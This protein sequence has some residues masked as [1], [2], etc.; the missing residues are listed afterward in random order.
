MPVIPVFKPLGPTSHDI[1]ASARRQLATRKVGHAGT[2][3]PLASGVLVLLTEEHTRLSKFMTGSEKSYLAWVSFGATTP[4]LDLEGPLVPAAPVDPMGLSERIE[5]ALP[6]FL[7]LSEQAPPGFSAVKRDGVKSY[8]A[9]R[10][11]EVPDLPPRP[12]GYSRI[13][14]LGTAGR[15]FDLPASF[16]PDQSGA[17]RPDAAGL[18]FER[19]PDLADLPS[20]LFFL[21]VQAGTYVRAFARDLGEA[22]GTGAHL[23]GL[24]RTQAG[25]IGLAHTVAADALAGAVGTDPVAALG[26]QAIRLD[27]QQAER[28][29]LGQRLRP[30]FEGTAVLTDPD[31]RIAAVAEAIE[32]RMKLH[33]VWPR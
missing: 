8:E 12:A 4:T 10:R 3:D 7:N 15:A 16:S 32:G 24:V 33:S 27:R 6:T 26:L 29:R 13:I 11:G 17:W 2:L 18:A 28:V 20:A 5:L 1:V 31:G 30:D 14:L 9:A 23:S 19:P 21:T 25:R 22:L